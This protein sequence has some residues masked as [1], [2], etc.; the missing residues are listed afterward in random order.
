MSNSSV[1]TMEPAS[2][3]PTIIGPMVVILTLGSILI[4]I[5]PPRCNIP[6]TGGFS[7]NSVPLPRA[8]RSRFLLPFLP[9]LSTEFGKPL[10]PATMYT[11]SISTIP[12]RRGSGALVSIPLLNLAAILWAVI[13]LRSSS[14]AI[15]LVERFKHIIYKHRIHFFRMTR[16]LENIVDVKS[17]KHFPQVLQM[18]FWQKVFV[19]TCPFRDTSMFSHSGHW[20]PY[21]QLHC[22]IT[23]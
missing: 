9:F 12:W 15:L 8:P 20:I 2:T 14:F 22:R 7:L 3:W 23:S 19:F 21:S 6:K 16:H 13:T 11:S 5:S 17:L 18:Y 10:W 4:T 1:H